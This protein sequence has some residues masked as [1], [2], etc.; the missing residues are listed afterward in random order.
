MGGFEVGRE[1]FA[2]QGL[3]SEMEPFFHSLGQTGS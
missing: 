3:V 1:A 2:I